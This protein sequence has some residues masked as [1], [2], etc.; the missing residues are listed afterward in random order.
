MNGLLDLVLLVLALFASI[1]GL[2]Y[3]LTV[4]D[5][6]TDRAPAERRTVRAASP[7]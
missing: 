7:R 6:Q 1:S 4:I 5:P 3:V 2:L